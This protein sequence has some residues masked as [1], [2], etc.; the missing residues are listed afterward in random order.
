[1]RTAIN[2][3]A[4]ASNQALEAAIRTQASIVLESEAF[5]EATLNGFLISGDDTALLMEV[6]GRPRIS[7]DD[8]VD[9]RCEAYVHADRR[10]RFTSVITAVP[11]WGASRSIAIER[12]RLIRVLERRRFLRATLAPSSGVELEWRHQ[13]KT[14]R[15]T[16]DLL[17]ISADGMACRIEDGI[18][19][20]LDR[21]YSVRV[22]FEL[23][24]PHDPFRFTARVTNKTPGSEGCAIVGLQFAT[25][26]EDAAAMTALRIALEGGRTNKVESE[27][28]V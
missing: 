19:A 28:F 6:T 25:R 18:A 13:G 8:I 7:F 23:P 20:C 11:S 16:V 26:T 4:E 27:V 5:G 22:Y 1:M 2:L 9:A 10:F 14:H 17:N 3:D 24:G 21:Q 12:P 15:H